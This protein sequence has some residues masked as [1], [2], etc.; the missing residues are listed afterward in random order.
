MIFSEASNK[1]F[2]ILSF[3]SFIGG[4]KKYLKLK[5][6]PKKKNK[7]NKKILKTKIIY[8][9]KYSKF[10]KK[11]KMVEAQLGPDDFNYN[12]VIQELTGVL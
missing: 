7:K 4:K 12:L 2:F 3:L 11:K 10:Q 9:S 1:I 6:Q 8:K 5:N